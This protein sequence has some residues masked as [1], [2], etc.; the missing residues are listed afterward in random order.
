MTSLQKYLRGNCQAAFTFVKFNLEV[1]GLSY[2]TFSQKQCYVGI[3]VIIFYYL[4]FEPFLYRHILPKSLIGKEFIKAEEAFTSGSLPI[5]V[6]L[7]GNSGSRAGSHR[8]ELYKIF[9]SLDFHVLSLDYR[10]E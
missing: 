10:G 1:K 6:Y 2:L 4:I 3:D 7:H 5:I 8:I 9:Q